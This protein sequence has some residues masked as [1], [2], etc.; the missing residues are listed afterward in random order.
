MLRRFLLS[1]CAEYASWP[2]REKLTYKIDVV[3]PIEVTAS[4][5]PDVTPVS[6]SITTR[7]IF[8]LPP[9]LLEKYKYLPSGDHTGLRSV[10]EPSVTA[11]GSPPLARTVQICSRCPYRSGRLQ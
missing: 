1:V 8:E 11:K 4:G 7:Q 10:E 9:R 6:S 3:A 2:L 5:A